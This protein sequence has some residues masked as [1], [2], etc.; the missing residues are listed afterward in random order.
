MGLASSPARQTG[1]RAYGTPATA[2]SCSS[3]RVTPDGARIIT[4]SDDNTMRVWDARTD[5]ALLRLEGHTRPVLR[6]AV[7]FDGARIIT[8]SG[9]NTAGVWDASTGAQ[10]L[11][12][13]GHEGLVRAMAV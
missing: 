2:P 4:G 12:L 1:P 5:T 7:T 3:S 8:G 6:V 13:K 10:I 9:D 11:E